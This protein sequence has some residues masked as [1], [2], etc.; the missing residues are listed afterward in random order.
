MRD[1][2]T[3]GPNCRWC[4]V[5]LILLSLA[6]FAILSYT[7]VATKSSTYDEPLH[8][9][10]GAVQRQQHDFRMDIEDPPLWL[11]WAEVLNWNRPLPLDLS[12]RAWREMPS[13]GRNE[14][15]FA[16]DTLYHTPDTDGEAYIRRCRPMQI[17]LGVAL[18]CVL[19]VFTWQIAGPVASLIAVVLFA[20]DPTFLAHAAL[21]K[22]DVAITLVIL[23]LVWTLWHIGRQASARATV[24]V[25]LLSALTLTVKFSGI[26]LVPVVLLLLTIRALMPFEWLGLGRT[27]TTRQSRLGFSLLLTLA[28]AIAAY[29]S[30]WA[31]Y[32][33]RFR[34]SSD[35]EPIDTQNIL[36]DASFSRT[37]YDAL[38]TG[39][40]QQVREQAAKNVSD[41]WST[42]LT[43]VALQH[44]VLPEAWLNGMLFVNEW[45]R[46]RPAYLCGQRSTTGWWYY[47]PLAAVFKSPLA[48]LFAAGILAVAFFAAPIFHARNAKELL[49]TSGAW[50][51]AALAVPFGVYGLFAA[52]SHLNI[53]TRHILPLYPFA[54]MAIAIGLS[55]LIKRR[56]RLGL[57]LSL[58]LL[59]M[60]VVE[61]IMSWP[62][63]LAFFN[64]ACGGPRGGFQL[65]ADSNL[66]WGQDLPLLARWQ[67]DHPNNR[68]YLS[69]PQTVDPAA[70]GIRFAALPNN[71]TFSQPTEVPSGPACVAISSLVLQKVYFRSNI[72]DE[73]LKVEPAAVLGG[74]I[75]IWEEND[76]VL[77]MLGMLLMNS[78][79]FPEAAKA[80][81]RAVRLQP[82]DAALQSNLGAAL[83][84]IGRIPE[85]IEHLRQSVKLNATYDETHN[86]LGSLLASTGAAQ[87]AITEF[88]RAIEL[89]PNRADFHLNLADVLYE[90]GQPKKAVEHCETALRLQPKFAHACFSL[91]KALAALNRSQEAIVAARRGIEVAK[92]SGQ[93]GEA[94]K[95]EDWLMHHQTDL[96]R[97]IPPESQPGSNPSARK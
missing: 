17:I 84:R 69:Y 83:A 35:G 75:Y 21:V 25:I 50:T 95:I 20:F 10:A 28:M 51:V 79:Q 66:D 71:S 5:F 67:R 58:A 37:V 73:L 33:F 53:G 96:Q 24:A 40:Q 22:N 59:A 15:R 4:F 82:D 94:E 23:V 85:A 76:V 72:Y 42:R 39:G 70:Y 97:P 63:Y 68:L 6:A 9:V 56:Q 8:A 60:L 49:K 43:Y 92:A 87:D 32:G 86:Y 1:S 19:A 65:L 41:D 30:V 26:L 77:N 16:V 80:L 89:G 29:T 61:T 13:V 90:N 74:S 48:T 36:L 93:K 27:L 31:S 52:S 47:F 64:A 78:N 7:A 45:A 18:G 2:A 11:Y 54:F 12:S 38:G 46:V 88:E 55:E 57:V 91:A 14:W 34:A 3:D 81:E 44:H 62:N